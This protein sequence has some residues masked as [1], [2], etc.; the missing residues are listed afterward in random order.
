M[1]KGMK[2]T[3]GNRG[4]LSGTYTLRRGARGRGND[5]N[6]RYPTE[7]LCLELVYSAG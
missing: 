2:S 7:G 1:R 4:G 5:A 6:V 3:S